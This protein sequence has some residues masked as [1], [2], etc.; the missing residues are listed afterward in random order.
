MVENSFI[1]RALH[2][3]VYLERKM[4]DPKIE[5]SFLDA[6]SSWNKEKMKG[7]TQKPWTGKAGCLVDLQ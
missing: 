1:L 7:V 3:A 6:L 4:K 5:T 2:F